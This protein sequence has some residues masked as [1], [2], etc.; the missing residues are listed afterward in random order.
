MS[1][2]VFLPQ[3]KPV[4]TLLRQHTEEVDGVLTCFEGKP[5]ECV[6]TPFEIEID[7]RHGESTE[8]TDESCLKQVQ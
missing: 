3:F 2:N 1:F 5:T 4:C 6:E 8:C 7:L